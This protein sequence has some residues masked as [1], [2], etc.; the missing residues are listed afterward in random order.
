MELETGDTVAVLFMSDDDISV[1]VGLGKVSKMDCDTVYVEWQKIINPTPVI[2]NDQISKTEW[3][4]SEI[5]Q[6]V[7]NDAHIYTSFKNLKNNYPHY[8]LMKIQYD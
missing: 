8:S 1:M 4:S 3:S 6:K 5:E 7:A 2:K